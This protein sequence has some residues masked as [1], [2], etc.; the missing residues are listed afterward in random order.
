MDIALSPREREVA[1]LVAEGLTNREIA[2]RL[3][4]SERTAEGHVEQIRNKLAF[5]SRTQIAGWVER[6]RAGIGARRPRIAPGAIAVELPRPI[7]VEIPR[8]PRQA[9]AIG[10]A[11]V[12]VAVAAVTFWPRAQSATLIAI[13]GIGTRG[14]S[15]DGGPATAAQID[16]PTS[17]VFD[18]D[19]ALVFADSFREAAGGPPAGDTSNRTHVRRIDR[20]GTV[21]TMVSDL[22]PPRTFNIAEVGHEVFV[23][24]EARISIGPDFA[25]YIAAGAGV[26][27]WIGRVDESGK[28]T[29]LAGGAPSAL[30]PNMR[31]ALLAPVGLAIGT[32]GVI[33]VSNT[34]TSEILAIPVRGDVVTIAGTG[35]RGA[36]G[37]GGPATSA[38][39]YAPPSIRLAPDASLHVVDTY[40]HRVRAID[41]GGIVV[42]VAG[43]GAR[44]FSGDGGPATQARMTLP[45]DIAFGPD[46]VMYVAD[47]GNARVRAVDVHGTITTVAGPAQLV[48]PSALAVDANGT[49]Y[50]G[51]GGAHRIFK[52]VRQRQ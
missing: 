1:D 23:P 11:V 13:A 38:T 41:H 3:V 24:P 19:G 29:W 40:N 2:E 7:Q 4:I 14:Y 8:V 51:D 15:G 49:L 30:A 28:F 21:R 9:A 35:E 46:G 52:V 44:G 12:L 5:H 42:T 31:T 27:N 6:Q 36:G 17:M 25:L 48:R 26:Q 10:L 37:D 43:S 22:S 32:D 39:F 45:A 50:I 20:S 16:E 34:G 33:Y 47:S 18:R